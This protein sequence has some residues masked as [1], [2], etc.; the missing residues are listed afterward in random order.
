MGDMKLLPG[1]ATRAHDDKTRTIME[2][3]IAAVV[4]I[5]LI[6]YIAG[7]ALMAW[8]AHMV[9]DKPA[10]VIQGSSSATH[11]QPSHSG[12]SATAT[13]RDAWASDVVTPDPL[14]SI[15]GVD[16][17]AGLDEKPLVSE[18]CG[19]CGLGQV[20]RDHDGTVL[21]RCSMCRRT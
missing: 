8:F 7:L 3:I 6:P 9:T 14:D 21:R 18:S 17:F 19:K 5:A 10:I 12:M 4:F 20:V 16:N 11:S 2:G 13:H 15:P 1:K